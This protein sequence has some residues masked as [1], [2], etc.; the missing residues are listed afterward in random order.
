MIMCHRGGSL[1]LSAHQS[2]LRHFFEVVAADFA[3]D[4]D[5]VLPLKLKIE[6]ADQAVGGGAGDATGLGDLVSAHESGLIHAVGVI[7]LRCVFGCSHRLF[8]PFSLLGF[9]GAV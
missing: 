2:K 4:C 1:R 6:L 9:Q 5:F 7:L 8:S 3:G